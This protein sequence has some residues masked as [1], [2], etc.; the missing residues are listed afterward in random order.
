MLPKAL[1]K[2]LRPKMSMQLTSEDNGMIQGK[3]S[4]INMDEML[5]FEWK[6]AIGDRLVTEKEFMQ[7]VK[8]FSG[9]VKLNDEF[10]FFDENEIRSLIAKLE[11]PPEMTGHQLLQVALTEDY[12]GA[13]VHLDKNTRE[14]IDNLLQGEGTEVPDGLQ[15]TL[16]PYQLRGYE[17]L[18]KNSRLGF[19]SLIAD[20]MGLG[21]TLQV[22]TT[23][24]KLKEDGELESH[25]ALIIVPTTL[26]TNLSL[27]HI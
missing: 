27:I 21:K 2:L 15:A 16:R 14:L 10:V 22:I 19:G 1:R 26:L 17:W 24:L 25:K 6:I 3:K 7:L 20:D 9:I 4:I 12:Q 8:Q 13:K 11:S 5:S 18:Y 23:L